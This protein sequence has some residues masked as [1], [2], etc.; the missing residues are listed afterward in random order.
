[1]NYSEKQL[2]DLA[3]I[4]LMMERSSR[5]LS[6]SGWSGISAGVLA[7]LGALAAFWLMRTS[8]AS[9]LNAFLVADALIVLALAI[10]F[11]FFFS[12]RKAKRKG[13]TLWSPVTKKLL[14]NM[15]I[16]LITG[17]IYCI[18]LFSQEQTQFIA[19]ATLIFYGLSLINA[20]RFTNQ[21]A[22]ILGIAE[23][24]LG[25]G[26][27]I[28]HSYSLWIWATGFGLFHIVYG[29]NLYYKYDRQE[30]NEKSH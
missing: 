2:Q 5:F 26:A 7:L 4:K 11:S 12:W 19:G 6:L 22:V 9:T 27:S 18:I 1:M 25:I 30:G 21:E 15:A 8:T 17:G 24:I 13:E 20:G 23:I 16:P 29:I 10:S 28:W 14:L 3:D